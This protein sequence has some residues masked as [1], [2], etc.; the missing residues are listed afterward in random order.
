MPADFV[1]TVMG[2]SRTNPEHE[3]LVHVRHH[4]TGTTEEVLT[5]AELD[6]AA[7]TIAIRLA[8]HCA[9]GDRALLLHPTGT[10]F[11][12]A[13]LGCMYA[14]VVPVPAPL[15]EGTRGR[16]SRTTGIALDTG[17]KV[18]LTDAADLADVTAWRDRD[19]L[20]VV[21][22]LA[23]DTLTA[24]P[25]E[26][27][28]W[29]RP[30][31][32]AL[33]FLQ[34]TSGSTSDPKGVMVTHRALTAN[35]TLIRDQLRFN[36]STRTFCWLP[37]YH[38]MGLIGLFLEPLFLGSTA[39]VMPPMD[40]LKRPQL[41]L[42]TMSRYGIEISSA[43]NFGYELAVRRLTDEH[44]ATLDL[45]R[46]THACN[47]AEPISAKTLARFTERFGPAG[48]RAEA[49]LPCYGMAE[50][51]LFVAGTPAD[52]VPV[53]TPVAPVALEKQLF[54][55]DADGVPLVSSGRVDGFDV[56][57]VDAESHQVLPDG[58]IGE[59]WLRGE[60]VAAGY[61]NNEA[62]TERVFR[63]RT[64]EGEE[65]FLRTGDLGVLDQ[66]ELYVT[67]R[68][69]EMVILNG[70]NVYP[71]DIEREVAAGH[72]AFAGLAGCVFAVPAPDEELVIVQEVRAAQEKDLPAL[73]ALVRGLVGEYLKTRA[74]NVV[75]VRPG[76]VRKT[77]SGKIQRSLMR[78]LFMDGELENRYEELD[79]AVRDRY[80]AGA[81]A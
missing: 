35:L 10:A 47:G 38:D 33:A 32:E 30:E 26:L 55:P 2:H 62:A 75:L 12:A 11:A 81:Q 41:W 23:S 7:R 56:R 19:G 16:Q 57:I 15:P 73:A 22:V 4:A 70:R 59:I 37:M 18:V 21:S 5:Y 79:T 24:E 14:G 39:Y 40:F 71:H 58:H 74:A 31:G 9:H 69:K 3:A 63:A 1:D 76:K 61:W 64:A 43:P 28:A 17:A 34:Y 50:T 46:W 13:L 29:R 44:I 67:G 80:R 72:V 52:R 65:E 48:F 77:T 78:K 51:T 36:R 42:Q 53:I 20:T 54:E 60:S 27:A 25:D 8:E 68:I 6:T 45:S 66:G 49:L